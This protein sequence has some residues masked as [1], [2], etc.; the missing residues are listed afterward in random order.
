[1][2][3][4]SNNNKNNLNEN[5]ELQQVRHYYESIIAKM[6]GHVFWK[7]KNG[8]FLGCNDQQA[9]TLGLSSWKEVIGK[10]TY[11]MI[12][13]GQ[14]EA[15]RRRQA[16]IIDEN[17]RLIMESG[18]PQVLEEPLIL[19]N[20]STAVY[21]SN[22]TPLYDEKGVAIG[23]LGF[24]VD[25]TAQKEAEVLKKE[26]EVTQH[27]LAVIKTLAATLAHELRTPLA[28][29]HI[30]A[31]SIQDYLEDLTHAYELAK[32]ANL[33]VR[34]I[35][36]SQ[37]RLLRSVLE[38]MI[39]ETRYSNTIIDMLWVNVEQLT[40]QQ[41]ALQPCSIAHC[42]EEAL[43][44]YPFQPNDRAL[45]HWEN[46]NDFTF[47]G[48]ELLTVHVLFNLLKNAIYYVKAA[49]AGDAEGSIQIWL[50]PGK[51]YN[52]LHF[53]D[54]GKG[55]PESILA[56]IFDPFFSKTDHGAGIGLTFC[57][58]VMESYGGTIRCTSKEDEF[59]EFALSFPAYTKE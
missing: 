48:N 20:G 44:R 6:P 21:L 24:S 41:S 16:A 4:I 3:G 59:T 56:N 58:S 47:M 13:H 30:G 17:D 5:K 23:I 31:S 14:S 37:I 55:M 40:L 18:V 35:F 52:V 8:V 45:I 46:K 42:I 49:D 39:D 11:D 10:T 19:P 36:P 26:F 32:N 15:E 43:R 12:W 54:A 2:S 50:E 9:K 28:A 38:G 33:P 57:K 7:D 53:K 34:E 22:K 25:I 27:Q 29:I 1:M 51:K